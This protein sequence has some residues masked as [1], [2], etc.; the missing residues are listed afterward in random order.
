M[1]AFYTLLVGLN[2]CIGIY[3]SN[4]P[5]FDSRDHHILLIAALSHAY[6]RS[7]R[8]SQA[9]FCYAMVMKLSFQGQFLSNRGTIALPSSLLEGRRGTEEPDADVRIVN[10]R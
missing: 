3:K 6:A 8:I 1:G 7:M 4:K 5:C 9:L 10:S 2:A